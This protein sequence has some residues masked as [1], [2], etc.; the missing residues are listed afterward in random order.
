MLIDLSSKPYIRYVSIFKNFK[1]EAGTSLTHD[2]SQIVAIPF[3]PRIIEVEID[4]SQK[5]YNKKNEEKGSRLI[6][7][8]DCFIVFTSYAS[9]QPMEFWIIPKRHDNTIINLT[10][11]EKRVFAKT[12]KKSLAALR[13][14]VN[15]P[16]YNYGFHISLSKKTNE[17]YHWHLEVFH[18]LSIWA[19]F[20]K[21]TGV[22]INTVLPERDALELRKIIKNNS[23]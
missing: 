1:K 23:L 22:Y 11:Y 15:D 2:H 7:Q 3:V 10:K 20:E 6:F 5:F 9:I 8:Y 4:A 16:A 12:L 18:K 19:G 14:L 13:L 17:H 21:N